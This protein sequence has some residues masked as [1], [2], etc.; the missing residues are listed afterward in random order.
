MNFIRFVVCFFCFTALPGFAS[1][2][3]TW[4]PCH[5]ENVSMRL[6]CI[7]IEVPKQTVGSGDTISIHVVK[8]AAA[9]SN[10]YA[11]P[12][13]FLA[14]G[15]GQ[16]A[17]DVVAS[18]LPTF[19]RLQTQRDIYFID[20]RGTGKSLP[21]FCAE[22]ITDSLLLNYNTEQTIKE[23]QNCAA[24]L[25]DQL[26]YFSTEQAVDD[27]EFI[28]KHLSI[29]QFNLYGGSYG[30]RVAQVYMRK[31][32]EAIRSV[33]LDAVVPM[34]FAI[35]DFDASVNESWLGLLDQCTQHSACQQAFPNLDGLMLQAQA[36]LAEAPA[37]DL[38]HP[39]QGQYIEPK[40]NNLKFL[41]SIRSMLYHPSTRALIPYTIKATSERDFRPLLSQLS[42]AQNQRIA[43]GLFLEIA[44]NE[45]FDLWQQ[46]DKKTFDFDR[47]IL[48]EQFKLMC[49]HWPDNKQN[50][51]LDRS[52]VKSDIP[53]LLISG[54]YDP[55]TPPSNAVDVAKGLSNHRHIVVKGASHTA[56]FHSCLSK[57]IDKFIDSTDVSRLDANCLEDA[58]VHWFMTDINLIE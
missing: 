33:I 52:A 5:V 2:L 8:V 4:Q 51:A 42:R 27:L 41:S 1:S 25:S 19:R 24:L 36:T 28:R 56:L 32:P 44:C 46:S 50:Y 48:A 45:D 21:L 58:N 53:T 40:L 22:P 15:P 16:A 39:T 26:G 57:S 43:N 10:V 23:T 34:N 6:E 29:P 17:S 18:V 13:L 54:E 49:E 12:L 31:Y 35:G 7:N 3:N 9:K 14:G 55:V 20:Q 30:T 37:I 47:G 38:P 11:D